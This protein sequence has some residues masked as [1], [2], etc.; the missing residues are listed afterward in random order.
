M[1]KIIKLLAKSGEIFCDFF[2]L[3]FMSACEAMIR[4]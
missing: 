3:S 1:R 2:K 4:A